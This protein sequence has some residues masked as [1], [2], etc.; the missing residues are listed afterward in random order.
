[1]TLTLSSYSGYT[2]FTG[3]PLYAFSGTR[4]KSQPLIQIRWQ[5]SD[6][7]ILETLPLGG[8]RTDPIASPTVMTPATPEAPGQSGGLSKGAKA[9]IGVGVTAGVLT[10]CVVA[11]LLLRH[12]RAKRLRR[13][14]GEETGRPS[15]LADDKKPKAELSTAGGVSELATAQS[16]TSPVPDVYEIDSHSRQNVEPQELAA[17]Y[18]P[19]ATMAPVGSS[20]HKHSPEAPGPTPHLPSSGRPDPEYSALPEAV[21]QPDH[22][23]FPEVAQPEPDVAALQALQ[24]RHAELEQE[25]QRILRLQQIQEEKDQLQRQISEMGGRTGGP[26]SA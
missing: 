3:S 2:C 15:E 26:S 9:G 20:G 23:A 25:E 5:S 12:Y 16:V 24:A 19:P 11:F 21:Q 17:G 8:T 1:M 4:S 13:Q 22:S 7:A 6:L 10:L 18:S 14:P